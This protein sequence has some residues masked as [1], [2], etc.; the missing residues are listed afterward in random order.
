MCTADNPDNLSN[1]QTRNARQRR[2]A[3]RIT[4]KTRGD[5]CTACLPRSPGQQQLPDEAAGTLQLH[6]RQ[7]G[8]AA[9]GVFHLSDLNGSLA[10]G[11][12][13]PSPSRCDHTHST[14]HTTHTHTHTHTQTLS[15]YSAT[16]PHLHRISLLITHTHEQ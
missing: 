11:A 12:C 14:P 5:R 15:A 8:V 3:S 1:Y 10:V 16:P 6:Q 4:V 7:A 2:S 9:V 13:S